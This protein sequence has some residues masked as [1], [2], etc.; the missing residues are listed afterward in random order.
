MYGLETVTGDKVLISISYVG[1]ASEKDLK[2]G[3]QKQGY[4]I[5]FCIL[6]KYIKAGL[7][8]CTHN[9]TLIHL[10]SVHP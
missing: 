6:K 10:L 3:V 5:L 4:D 8:A 2:D 7:L 1:S 9:N